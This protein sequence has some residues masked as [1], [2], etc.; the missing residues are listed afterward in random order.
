MD[1]G[2]EQA[3]IAGW[4]GQLDAAVEG[5]ADHGGTGQTAG[6][7][8]DYTK[9]ASGQGVGGGGRRTFGGIT[10]SGLELGVDG[11]HQAVA[12]LHTGEH[13]MDVDIE[14]GAELVTR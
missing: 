14:T 8:A 7:V 9:R 11:R 5:S 1:V 4:V 6:A 12:G 13:G 2:R 3:G 10:Q